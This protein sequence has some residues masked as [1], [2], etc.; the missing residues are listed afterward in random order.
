MYS[1]LGALWLMSRLSHVLV[2][3]VKNVLNVKM[4]RKRPSP[5]KGSSEISSEEK[6]IDKQLREI[7]L[8]RKP[9]A[10]DGS[11]LF[12]A[13]SEQVRRRQLS[14]SN[15][16]R[17]FDTGISKSSAPQG[18]ETGVHRLHATQRRPIRTGSLSIKKE[19]FSSIFFSC[20]VR[21]RSV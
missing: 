9:V 1:F 7:G 17:R 20:L 5:T 6:E 21:R 18:R 12:R 16:K 15:A 3:R 10:K 19:T 4:G 11:C 13:V 8:W 2:P 14:E